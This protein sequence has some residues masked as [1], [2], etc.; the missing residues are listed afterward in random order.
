MPAAA[1][2]Y[3]ASS[4]GATASS[5]A[6]GRQKNPNSTVTSPSRNTPLAAHRHNRLL[7][8]EI[9]VSVPKYQPDRGTV[10]TRAPMV[11]EKPAVRNRVTQFPFLPF[12][13]RR[14]SRGVRNRMPA[15]AAKD[16]CKLMDAAAKGFASKIKNKAASKAVGPS[17]S[18]RNSGAASRN[19]S[20][21]QARRTEG[22]PPV[23]AA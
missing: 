10:N 16:N 18:R 17:L 12:I 23:R 9:S 19:A 22:L 7:S 13:S 15:M 8:G 4:A 11:A 14:Y 21:T 3:R 6:S 5:F 1:R 2:I 20:M